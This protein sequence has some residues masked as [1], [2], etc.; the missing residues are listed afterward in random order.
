M[1][2]EARNMYTSAFP[3]QFFSSDSMGY[4]S[5]I[6][7]RRGWCWHPVANVQRNE[8]EIEFTNDESTHFSTRQIFG[9]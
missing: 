9:E 5:G 8:C 2:D 3:S 7:S 4:N 6:T 1:T